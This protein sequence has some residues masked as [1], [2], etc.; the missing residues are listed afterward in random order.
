MPLAGTGIAMTPAA[1]LSAAEGVS[2]IRS[3]LDDPAL[4]SPDGNAVL[5]QYELSDQGAGAVERIDPILES[6]AAAQAVHPG[7]TVEGF[8]SAIG[9]KSVDET[10]ASD[11]QRA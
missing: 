10:I 9:E 6:V 5:V 7:F 2:D 4:V 1:R 8:G 11:F 3:P